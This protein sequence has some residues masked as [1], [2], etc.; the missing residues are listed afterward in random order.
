MKQSTKLQPIAN[1]RKQQEHNAGRLHGEARQEMERQQ[2]QL[3]ELMSYREE[4]IKG[5]ESVGKSGLSAIQ[6]QEYRL[7]I[8]RL[9]E[10]IMQQRQ[11]VESEKNKCEV[12]HQE[13]L[14]KRS[15]SKIINKVVE[16]RQELEHLQK[17]QAEQKELENR[18]HTKFDGY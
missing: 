3:D 13:W 11:F 8:N 2:K 1:I 17:E 16:N 6:A 18:P 15:K 12:S 7:F 10:A 9:D 4:Y 5:F 14:H